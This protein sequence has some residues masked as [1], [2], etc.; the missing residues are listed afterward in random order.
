[1]VE[2]G[3]RG[4]NYPLF[5]AFPCL[6]DRSLGNSL[7]NKK[8]DALPSQEDQKARFYEECRKVAE[9]YDKEFPKKYDE[10]LDATPTPVSSV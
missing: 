5:R 3:C 10:N 9:E 7:Y 4:F 1:M 8:Q 6:F 2:V